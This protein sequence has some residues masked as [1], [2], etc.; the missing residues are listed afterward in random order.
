MYNRIINLGLLNWM[1]DEG[2]LKLSYHIYLNRKLDLN[3]PQTFNEKL[4]WLKI[5]DRNPLYIQYVDKYEVRKYIASRFGCDL[6]IPV[7]G[8]WDTADDI[9]FQALPEQYVLKCTHDSGSICICDNK[10]TFDIDAAKRKLNNRL[11]H[12]LF[13][14][15]REWPYKGVKPR[16]I[17]EKYM[18]DT[19]G[20]KELTDFKLMCFNGKVRCS[21]T[22]TDRFSEDGLKVTFFDREWN[23]MP[24]ERHYPADKKDIPKP[25]SYDRMVVIAE[26][27]STGHPFM[28]IDFYEINEQVFFGE[29]TLYPGNGMEE[30][31]PEEWD[32]KLGEWIQLDEVK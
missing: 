8:V 3:N 23:R 9:D 16:I 6:L 7:Y 19:A 18:V 15:G 31:I 22:V 30:F 28:R 1:S 21:F 12:N 2:F 14:W 11:R 20:R 5:H 17:A 32:L 29:I 24:F 4:Q 26:E 13:Y 25:A 10:K 27:I